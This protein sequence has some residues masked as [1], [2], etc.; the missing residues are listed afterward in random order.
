MKHTWLKDVIPLNE[1]FY[2]HIYN[3][4]N[5]DENL[6]F[7]QENYLCFLRKYDEYFSDCL[8]TYSY[9]LLPNHFHFLVRVKDRISP[10]KVGQKFYEGAEKVISEK[11]RRFFMAYAKAINKQQ[12]R[13]GS[14]FQ[15]NYKRKLVDSE[16]YYSRLIYYIHANPQTHGI[17]NDFKHYPHSSYGRILLERPTKLFKADVL[18]WFGS[19]KDYI[20]FHDSLQDLKGIEHLMIEEVEI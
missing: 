13:N 8:E 17:V 12:G 15:K 9:C 10:L 3:R 16:D 6:F 14:L 1:G 5:G 20:G 19:K 11:F 7:K 4:A 18:D 2:Y